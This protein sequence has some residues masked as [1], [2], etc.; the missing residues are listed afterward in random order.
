MVEK[1]NE[2]I[3]A[4]KVI[5]YPVLWIFLI[6]FLFWKIFNI[7]FFN[8]QDTWWDIQ[9]WTMLTGINLP[10]SWNTNDVS[11][12]TWIFQTWF[13]QLTWID[14]E[15]SDIDKVYSVLEKGTPWVD[16]SVISPRPQNTPYS[17]TMQDDFLNYLVNNIYTLK[18]PDNIEWWWLYIKLKKPLRYMANTKTFQPITIKTNIYFQDRWTYWRLITTK[19]LWVYMENQEFLYDLSNVPIRNAKWSNWLTMR[20]KNIQIGWF[21]SDT[22]GNY[23]EKIIFIWRRK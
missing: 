11:V 9:T 18:M 22:N 6:V 16:Y 21:V 2:D 5:F 23:I 14:I 17:S 20:W 7:P 8:S 1:S 13:D 4:L 19:S 10:V 15:I 12:I 3:R